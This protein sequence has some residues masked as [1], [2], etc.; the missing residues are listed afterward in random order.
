MHLFHFIYYENDL[1]NSL[2]F[3]GPISL[4]FVISSS[5]IVLAFLLIVFHQDHLFLFLELSQSRQVAFLVVFP[6]IDWSFIFLIG[7]DC[8]ETI[9]REL[10]HDGLLRLFFFFRQQENIIQIS[11][12]NDSII[13]IVLIDLY[14]SLA[15][16]RID[17][18]Q[19]QNKATS[20]PIL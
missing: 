5:Q 12:K 14:R 16:S 3:I 18:R 13:C 11:R 9:Y 7:S 1:S 15:F 4:M 19:W 10:F 20:K 17:L 2:I 8:L 6:S